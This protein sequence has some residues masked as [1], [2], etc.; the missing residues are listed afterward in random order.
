MINLLPKE[1]DEENDQMWR[2]PW[3]SNIAMLLHD[4]YGITDWDKRNQAATDILNMIYDAKW[5]P[6]DYRKDK[7]N[8]EMCQLC[9]NI[10]EENEDLPVEVPKVSALER[11]LDQLSSRISELDKKI[12][13]LNDALIP[14]LSESAQSKPSAEVMERFGSSSVSQILQE[15]CC[16]LFVLGQKV[17]SLLNHLEV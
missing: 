5:K 3:R 13:K 9:K 17:E 11:T 8:K 15:S 12:S 10:E 16:R 2:Y 14:V 7:E 1:V 6:I 4:R